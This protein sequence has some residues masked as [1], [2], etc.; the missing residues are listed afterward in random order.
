MIVYRDTLNGILAAKGKEIT[1]VSKELGYSA[2]YLSQMFRGGEGYDAPVPL[3]MAL[4]HILGCTEDEL[5]RRPATIGGGEGKMNEKI[6]SI[7]GVLVY[8]SA[9]TLDAIKGLKE[10]IEEGFKQLHM[11][12]NRM[13]QLW[14]PEEK[15]TTSSG[16]VLR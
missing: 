12:M 13:I 16:K 15:L 7:R 2:T 1:K 6:D 5:A 4:C 8:N 14:K 11:D 10:T 3:A 9:E